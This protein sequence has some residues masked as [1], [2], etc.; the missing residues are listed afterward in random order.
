MNQKPTPNNLFLLQGVTWLVVFLLMFLN[1]LQYKPWLQGLAY[2]II[3]LCVYMIIIYVHA[4]WLIPRFFL[5]KKYF[6]YTLLA[7]VLLVV[8]NFGDIYFSLYIQ[9][10]FFSADKVNPTRNMIL[11]NGINVILVFLVSILFILAMNYF[12]LS[13]AQETAKAERV[14]AELGLLKQQLQP[15][16]LFNTLNNIYYVAQ[17]KSPEAADLIERLSGIMRYFIEESPR[18]KVMLESEIELLKSYIELER[19]RVKNEIEVEFKLEGVLN[20]IGIHPLL[21]MPIVENIFKHGIDKRSQVNIIRL[22]LKVNQG[23]LYFETQNRL[24]LTTEQEYA[25]GIGIANLKKRLSLYYGNNYEVS[26]RVV[27]DF[28]F[29]KVNFPIHEL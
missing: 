23:R 27:E 19:I 28:Y 14:K 12:R 13:N 26:A 24:V 7:I 6:V 5:A 11:S 4:G 15:H 29:C 8:L 21:L 18:E 25:G 1:K 3:S 22:H 16:F 9:N 17:K 20:G 10:T 2:S